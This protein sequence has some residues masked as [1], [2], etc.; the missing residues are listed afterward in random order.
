MRGGRSTVHG[1]LEFVSSN[2]VSHMNVNSSRIQ[3]TRVVSAFESRNM[4]TRFPEVIMLE[5]VGQDKV[6]LGV[7]LNGGMYAMSEI[8]AL[9]KSSAHV[10]TLIPSGLVNRM[11]RT[12]VRDFRMKG[13]TFVWIPV[14]PGFDFLQIIQQRSSLVSTMRGIL[15]ERTVRNSYD[16]NQ[17]CRVLLKLHD[18]LDFGGVVSHR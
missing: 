3:G 4:T 11:V 12:T 17:C 10:V 7:L 1:K 5:S 9:V 2:G 16:I 15:R 13:G 18:G 6:S 14:E 8:P